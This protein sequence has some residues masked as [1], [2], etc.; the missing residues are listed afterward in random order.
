MILCEKEKKKPRNFKCYVCLFSSFGLMHQSRIAG[1]RSH[2]EQ[3]CQ[4]YHIILGSFVFVLPLLVT[5]VFQNIHD[6]NNLPTWENQNSLGN[7]SNANKRFSCGD[8]CPHSLL[9]GFLAQGA[10]LLT[11]NRVL[12]VSVLS[13]KVI[14]WNGLIFVWNKALIELLQFILIMD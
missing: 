11:G 13:R 5:L 9:L 12:R 7:I 1:E 3:F 8:D 14:F 6:E 2:V 10:I 4:F